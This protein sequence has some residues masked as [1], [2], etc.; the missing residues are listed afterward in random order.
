MSLRAE[1]AARGRTFRPHLSLRQLHNCEAAPDLGKA[2]HWLPLLLD[3][4][5]GQCK[6]R[7][8]PISHANAAVCACRNAGATPTPIRVKYFAAT[9]LLSSIAPFNTVYG[10]KPSTAKTLA[11]A[12]LVAQPTTDGYMILEVDDR[13]VEC[14]LKCG[15][16]CEKKCP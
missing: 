6:G 1:A 12:M 10:P 14:L 13:Q 16:E 15:A 7:S 8:I 2:M 9:G 4:A 11:R 5:F 3:A